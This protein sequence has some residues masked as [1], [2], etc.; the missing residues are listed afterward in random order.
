MFTN[1]LCSRGDRGHI[2]HGWKMRDVAFP[3]IQSHWK[4]T[5]QYLLIGQKINLHV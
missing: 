2:E 1:I 4:Y 3:I 5:V